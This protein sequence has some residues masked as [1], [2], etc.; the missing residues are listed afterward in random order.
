MVPIENVSALEV[1]DSRGNPTLSV[2]VRTGLGSGTAVVPSGASTGAHEA[3]ELRDEDAGRYGGKGVQQAI[4]NVEGEISDAVEGMDVTGQA[5]LDQT[6]IDLDGTPNK[7]RLGANAILGVSLAASH[8]AAAGF[9]QPLYRYLGGA[10]AC[11]LPLPMANIL[12]GGVHADN[13]VD[14]QEFMVCPVGSETYAAGLRAVVEVY[15]ALH[16]V[17]KKRSLSTGVGDE[18]GFAPALESNEEALELVVAGIEQAGY[19]PGEDVALALDVAASE[20]YRE[21]AYRLE[22]EG[23]TLSREELVG[24][25]EEWVRRY[26]IVSI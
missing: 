19:R 26:P 25:Y 6:L 8:A 5:E 12:N 3:V 17:L 22:G 2:T 1:L 11:V 9:D 20:L 16:R 18:G 7:G 15:Q 13:N 10:Q 14:L 24:L 4:A 21:G 23:R